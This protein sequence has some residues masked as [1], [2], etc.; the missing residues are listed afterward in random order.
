MDGPYQHIELNFEVKLIQYRVPVL[1]IELHF[2]VK[3]IE[4]RVLHLSSSAQ[5]RHLTNTGI[6]KFCDLSLQHWPLFMG[7][8]GASAVRKIYCTV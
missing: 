4:Y 3:L 1:H 8:G 2:E 6:P 7:G 5:A